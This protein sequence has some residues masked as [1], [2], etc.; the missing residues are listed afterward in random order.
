MIILDGEQEIAA[1]RKNEQLSVTCISWPEQVALEL[2]DDIRFV[3]HH[4]YS[5]SSLKQHSS[6]R[7]VAQ[8]GHITLISS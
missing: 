7:H 2:D 1:K 4:V 5:T 3:L 6:D 8:L